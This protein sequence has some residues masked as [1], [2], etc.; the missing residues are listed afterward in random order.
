MGDI[1][2]LKVSVQI[3]LDI[4]YIC[5]TEIF[6]QYKITLK[7]FYKDFTSFSFLLHLNCIILVKFNQDQKAQQF[8]LQLIL[9]RGMTY[10]YYSEVLSK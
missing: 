8:A 5:P 2:S 10:F 9:A 4:A 7:R 1:L 3:F 6:L